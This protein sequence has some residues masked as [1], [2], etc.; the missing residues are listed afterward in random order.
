MIYSTDDDFVN[1]LSLIIRKPQEGKTRICIT[2]ITNDKT[3]NIHIV[4]TM[5]TLSAGMQFFGRMEEHIGSNRIVVFNS[6]KKTAGK[7]HYAK[8][9]S[10]VLDKIRK[11][12]DIKVIVCCAH[13]KRIRND[14]PKILQALDDSNH[15]RQENRKIVIHVDE[16]HEYI[17]QNRDYIRE[18]NEC[19]LV[20]NIYGYSA[21]PIKIWVASQTDDLFHKIHITDVEK[22]LELIRSPEY[23]GVNRCDFCIYDNMTHEDILTAANLDEKIPDTVLKRSGIEKNEN[24]WYGSKFPFDLGNEMLYLSFLKYVL[25]MMN[26]PQ[27]QYSYNFIPGYMRKVTHYQVVDIII[28]HY[29]DANV[30]VLNSNGYE[31]YRK[32]KHANTTERVMIDA[33]LRKGVSAE[34]TKLLLEPSYVIQKMIEKW[35]NSPTFITG[36]I[37]VGM[38]V[39]LVSE[40]LG[41]FDNIVMA[42]EQLNKDKLYQLC[43]FLFNYTNWSPENKSKIKTTRFHS[44]SKKVVDTC[45]DYERDVERL[46]T[47]FSGRSITLRDIDGLEPE[48]PTERELKKIE[49]NSLLTDPSQKI[50][51]KFKVYDGNDEEMWKRANEYYKTICGKYI[52][53]RSMPEKIDEFYNCSTTKTKGIQINSEIE[54]M[55]EQSWWSTFQ[56]LKNK[57]NYARVFVGYDNKN[58]SSEYTIYIKSVCLEINERTIQILNKYSKNKKSNNE[59]DSDCDSDNDSV[60]TIVSNE[61]TET[62]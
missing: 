9:D 17:P 21:S 32:T 50:W 16:A 7:C 52:I 53:G 43:R 60:N 48:E 40:T 44:L 59:T 39:T 14:I 2:N 34:E 45:I 25:P 10:D 22:E 29:T 15:F 3:K 20:T 30:I 6:N 18:Y 42:H 8:T 24:H 37:C 23:F 35:P 5:S 46:S 27:D 28:D 26:L 61:T 51:K 12:K 31:L 55:K 33:Q 47:D 19:N 49:L 11:N 36:F 38:S 57:Y 54:R 56:L 1:K 58:D 62:A 4:I 41:N 13:S